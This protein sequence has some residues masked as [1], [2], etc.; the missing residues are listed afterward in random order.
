MSEI[1]LFQRSWTPNTQPADDPSRSATAPFPFTSGAI[2][3]SLSL[4]ALSSDLSGGAD[5]APIPAAPALI[6]LSHQVRYEPHA[7]GLNIVAALPSGAGHTAVVEFALPN[8]IISA[9]RSHPCGATGRTL[10][11]FRIAVPIPAGIHPSA[12]HI[13]RDGDVVTVVL[14]R[15]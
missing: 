2:W 3:S 8:V 15:R 5:Y 1:K 4:A 9:H 10:E 13:S 7:G 12:I 6:P 14:P 11:Q